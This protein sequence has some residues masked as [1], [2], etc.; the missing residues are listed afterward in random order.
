[1]SKGW[2]TASKGWTVAG[3]HLPA[4]RLK[5]PN[6][7]LMKH[8][9]VLMEDDR[10]ARNLSSSVRLFFVAQGEPCR[11]ALPAAEPEVDG[12]EGEAGEEDAQLPYD[13]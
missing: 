1:M 8:D 4:A 2:T 13:R 3:K 5:R 7:G 11:L 9:T 12:V 6:N 10:P